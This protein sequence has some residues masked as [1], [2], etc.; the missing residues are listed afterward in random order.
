MSMIAAAA[1]RVPSPRWP[2][3]EERRTLT[4][5]FVDIVGSTALVDRLDPE[6]V[7]AVQRAYFDTVSGVLRRWNGVVEKYVGDAVMALFGARE[8]DGFDAYRAV[9][10]GLEIQRALDRRPLTGDVVL[11]VRVGVATGEA[12]VELPAVRDGGHGVAS[13]AVITT[14]ARL[15]EYAPPGGVVCCPVTQRATAGLVRQRQLTPVTVP[16]RAPASGIWQVLAPIGQPAARHDGPL[17]GRRR[18]LGTA[19]DRIIRAIREG[20]P[21]WVSVTGPSGSGRSRLLHELTRAVDVVDGAPVR[22]CV[23]SCPPHPHESLAPVANLLR[24][25]VALG[26]ADP[27]SVVRGRLTGALTGLLPP[28][29]LATAVPALER[30]LAAPD[31]T[32]GAAAA[33]F[34]EVLLRLAARG[35][36]VV[37]IDD[38][39]R[40]APAVDRFLHALFTAAAARALPMAVVTLH[41]TDRAEELPVA[42]G[43]RCRVPLRP[44][45]PV[46][47]GRLLRQLL[48][49]SGQPVNRV[50]RLLPLVGDT[51]GHAAAYVRSLADGADPAAPPLPEALVRAVGAEVDRLDGTR[52]AALMA[53]ATLPDG[54]TADAVERLLGWTPGQARAALAALRAADLL[55][56]LTG[57]RYAL[58]TPALRRVAAGRLPRRLRAAFASRAAER[59]GSEVPAHVVRDASPAGSA[60]RRAAGRSEAQSVR[61]GRDG[62]PSTATFPVNPASAPRSDGTA[63]RRDLRSATEN[64]PERPAGDRRSPAGRPGSTDLPAWRPPTPT[65][66]EL[67]P[68]RWPDR[69]DPAPHVHSDAAAPS[70]G[71]PPVT[72]GTAAA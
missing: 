46:Q 53:G 58:A 17:V 15:Q 67:R 3:P 32:A 34:H 29:R 55:I 37:G 66:R 54:F 69:A 39:D 8:S 1:S 22:W 48:V 43:R 40:A 24:D 13:G 9:R 31:A 71:S 14:A 25:L 27:P 2:V 59:V 51:P 57:G 68:G 38:L 52:R 49:R 21:Q 4:V 61:P 20:S 44:L 6:D 50:D 62:H 42:A 28:N 33:W 35:P 12:V 72:A 63:R 65:S 5:L 7:R 36:L 26:T 30:L 41:G 10:A 56:A 60:P 64:H 45:A 18:E 19:R 11:R 16:G 23:A 47:T 70:G